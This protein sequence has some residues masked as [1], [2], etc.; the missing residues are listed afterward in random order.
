MRQ[1]CRCGSSR[2]ADR[3]G[4]PRPRQ[5]RSNPPTAPATRRLRPTSGSGVSRRDRDN[6]RR[7]RSRCPRTRAPRRD[8]NRSE[9]VRCRGPWRRW[10]HDGSERRTTGIGLCRQQEAGAARDRALSFDAGDGF[11]HASVFASRVVR[12]VDQDQ[13]RPAAREWDQRGRVAAGQREREDLIVRRDVARV[14]VDE[15]VPVAHRSVHRGQVHVRTVGRNLE[16]RG[17]GRRGDGD[18]ARRRHHRHRRRDAVDDEPGHD[19]RRDRHAP[20][21]QGSPQQIKCVGGRDSGAE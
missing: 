12:I 7:P 10:W 17:V 21:W 9:I 8:R 6:D 16:D 14:A 2:A 11:D 4:R 5:R 15:R 18:A 3:R 20:A 1:A 13:Q 19:D